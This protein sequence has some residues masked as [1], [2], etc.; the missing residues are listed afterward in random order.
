MD[1]QEHWPEIKSVFQN[2][3][4][5]SRHCAIATVNEDGSPHITPIGSL[6]LR[7][8][9]TGYFF[10]EYSQKMADN[11]K[12]NNRICI[13]AI[14]SGIRYW[15]QSI[16][17]G[18]FPSPPGVRLNGTVG[19]RRKGTEEEI[20]S[21]QK[22]VRFARNLKGYKLIWKNMK[23]VREISFHSFEPVTASKMTRHLWQS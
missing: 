16:F 5:T 8:N 3:Q 1:I 17:L 15:Y 22:R 7:D 12:S 23:H 18:R 2:A 10:E 11:F 20:A 9:C 13:L 21:F 4:T 6:F 19:Q 14:N